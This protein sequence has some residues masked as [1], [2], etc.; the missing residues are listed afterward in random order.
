ML[1]EGKVIKAVNTIGKANITCTIAFYMLR[2]VSGSMYERHG[3]LVAHKHIYILGFA[4]VLLCFVL[5]TA[6]RSVFRK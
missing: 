5:L 6:I 4:K 2:T 3:K 1:T